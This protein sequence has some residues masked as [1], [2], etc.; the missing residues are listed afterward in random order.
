MDRTSIV[1]T[2]KAV[3]ADITHNSAVADA[4]V[5]TTLKEDLGIDSMTSLV[6]L[7]ALEDNIPGFVVDADTLE[8]DHFR[9]INTICEYVLSQL[10]QLEGNAVQFAAS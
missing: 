3:L 5:N 8:A 4:D 10:G 2:V 1:E 7:M 9:T 6:F